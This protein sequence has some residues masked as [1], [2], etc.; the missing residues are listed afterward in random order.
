MVKFTA[1]SDRTIRSENKVTE[2]VT[3]RVTEKE[4]EVLYLLFENSNYTTKELAEKLSLSR[5]TISERL[6]SLKGKNII[7]RVGSDT[8]GYWEIIEDEK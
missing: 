1:P 4:S 3:E 8:K 5:K 2:R 7:R 6:K